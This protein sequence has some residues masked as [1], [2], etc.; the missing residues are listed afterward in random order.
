MAE[1]KSAESQEKFHYFF[2]VIVVAL[3]GAAVLTAKFE[4]PDK[5]GIALELAGWLL[6]ML[7]L[8]VAFLNAWNVQHL[9]SRA[10]EAE[11]ARAI[12]DQKDLPPDVLLNA[13][14]RM[15]RLN[16]N[17]AGLEEESHRR[18]KTQLFF[19]ILGI[20]CIASARGLTGVMMLKTLWRL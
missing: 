12:L 6:F 3:L 16:T 14:E 18:F 11:R 7:S 4:S 17:L 1:I 20:F 8:V 5:Y 10:G 19:F 2:I 15:D 9:F 13:V